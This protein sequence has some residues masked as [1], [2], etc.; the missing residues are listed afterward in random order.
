MPSMTVNQGSIRGVRIQVPYDANLGF[1]RKG[2]QVKVTDGGENSVLE[3]LSFVV[4]GAIN[5]S[6][7]WNTTIE[8]DVDLKSVGN[9]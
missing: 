3:D 6:Y 2:L 5:S 9:G 7:G 1:I 8:C 4:N